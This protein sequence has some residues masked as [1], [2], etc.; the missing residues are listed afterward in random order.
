MS[1][2]IYDI[3]LKILSKSPKLLEKGHIVFMFTTVVHELITELI[4]ENRQEV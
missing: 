4:T 2:I 3:A 1:H